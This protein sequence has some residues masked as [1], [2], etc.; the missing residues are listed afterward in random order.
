MK[1]KKKRKE[2]ERTARL[3]RRLHGKLKPGAEREQLEKIQVSE[4]RA[5]M[6]RRK[7][8]KPRSV[9]GKKS[10]GLGAEPEF[11]PLQG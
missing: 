8:A 6:S 2:E 1:K 10:A 9:K 5:E 3:L 7:Q 11:V 4:R